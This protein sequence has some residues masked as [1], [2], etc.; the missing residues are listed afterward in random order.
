MITSQSIVNIKT[1]LL[2]LFLGLR[3]GREW[4]VVGMALGQIRTIFKYF[5]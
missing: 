1:R 4:D 3:R 2:A 5:F